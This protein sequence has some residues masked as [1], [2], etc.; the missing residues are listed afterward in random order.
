MEEEF[1]KLSELGAGNLN[2]INGSLLEHLCGTKDLLKEWGASKTLQNAGLYHAVYG[3]DGFSEK[4][5]STELRKDIAKIIGIEAE[6]IV[7]EYCAC[8]RKFFLPKIGIEDK[9]TFKN[10]FNND[11]YYLNDTLLMNFCELTV[12]NEVEIAIGD[13]EFVQNHGESL[14]N[15]FMNMKPLLSKSANLMAQNVFGHSYA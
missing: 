12:A 10:K 11:A 4:L 5:V 15:I 1:Q 3:T 6:K 13:E 7:Y 9:P 14:N 2:H 8:D